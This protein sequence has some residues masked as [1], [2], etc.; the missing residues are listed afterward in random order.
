MVSGSILNFLIRHTYLAILPI[1]I[2]E[3]PVLSVVLGFLIHGGY[4]LF[5]PAYALMILGDFLPDTFYYYIGRRGKKKELLEK[6]AFKFESVSANYP[7]LEK[8]WHTHPKKTMIMVKLAYGISI[9][10]L[11]SAGLAKVPYRL[12]IGMAM[13]V[14][15]IQYGSLMF[16]GYSLGNAY[17]PALQYVRYA[18]ILW[19]LILL[20]FVSIYISISRYAKKELSEMERGS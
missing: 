15:T 16:L 1:A 9:P 6:Y 8:L 17:E 4:L 7:I 2:I 19:A 10:F 13:L 20:I 5:Y 3:G 11:I 14:T 18:G 12:Y